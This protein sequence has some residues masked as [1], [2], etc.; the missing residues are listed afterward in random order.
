MLTQGAPCLAAIWPCGACCLFSS[1]CRRSTVL[2]WHAEAARAERLR[3]GAV[4]LR[5]LA[6]R[7]RFRCATCGNK[8]GMAARSQGGSSTRAASN[9]PAN[10]AA[11]AWPVSI[12]M[13][14]ATSCV[15]PRN[16]Y[17]HPS[18]RQV[19]LQK[20]VGWISVGWG[21]WLG[22]LAG[23]GRQTAA[24]HARACTAQHTTR[25]R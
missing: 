11:Q 17:V 10:G 22:L 7:R 13:H 1:A 16:L 25:P 15:L 24:T 20:S 9:L 3:C 12:V 21:W 4:A 18:N 14:E 23:A 5:A 6:N 8:S 19:W 2:A